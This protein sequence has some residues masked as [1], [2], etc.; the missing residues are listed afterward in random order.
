MRSIDN[1][2]CTHSQSH[3]L[4]LLRRT[5]LRFSS[6][7]YSTILNASR[8]ELHTLRET[9]WS[10]IR[11][12][13]PSFISKDCNAQFLIFFRKDIFC[14]LSKQ[15]YDKLFSVYKLHSFCRQCNK[16]VEVKTEVLLN[17]ISLYHLLSAHYLP[18][19]WPSY[20]R[21]CNLSECIQCTQCENRC[22]TEFF[23]CKLSDVI[24]VEFSSSMMPASQFSEDVLILENYKL[25]SMVRHLGSH[26]TCAVFENS[27]WYMY[28]DM[29]ESCQVF[30]SLS[31]LFV[32]N[33]SGWFFA[34]YIK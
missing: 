23:E 34:V 32:Q 30:K 15:E 14:D 8:Q 6:L 1:L 29:L 31:G 17:Y 20:I 24:F 12:K 13:C 9:L 7:E 22:V 10:F 18:A 2:F 16:D 19:D 21:A 25:C 26:F 5:C 11:S 4:N 28:D 27:Q 3:M 33:Y